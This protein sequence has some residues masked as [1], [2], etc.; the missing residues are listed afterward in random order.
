MWDGARGWQLEGPGT[1]PTHCGHL[2]S[3]EPPRAAAPG[4]AGHWGP[5]RGAGPV[6]KPPS[7]LGSQMLSWGEVEGG[8]KQLWQGQKGQKQIWGFL[9]PPHLLH[10]HNH[11]FSSKTQTQRTA[12]G[13]PRR[14]S[15]HNPSCPHGESTGRSQSIRGVTERQEPA[16]MP[17]DLHTCSGEGLQW[18]TSNPLLRRGPTSSSKADGSGSRSDRH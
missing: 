8:E 15:S 16:E 18:E 1:A 2:Q 13:S 11:G 6:P 3:G 12:P 10:R 17:P 9:K 7:G 4:L 14:A 5:G